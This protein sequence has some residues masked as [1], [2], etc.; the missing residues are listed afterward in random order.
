MSWIDF[1]L[2]YYFFEIGTLKIG[3][4]RIDGGYYIEKTT[5]ENALPDTWRAMLAYDRENVTM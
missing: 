5:F 4:R 3:I 2:S 1:Y